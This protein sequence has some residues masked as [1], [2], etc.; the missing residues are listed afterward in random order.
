MKFKAW[1]CVLPLKPK[2]AI[3]PNKRRFP[4]TCGEVHLTSEDADECSYFANVDEPADEIYWQPTEIVVPELRDF[5]G[6]TPFIP[7]GA[8]QIA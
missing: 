1:T 5:D 2:D 7:E 6:D 8:E 3:G 4:R